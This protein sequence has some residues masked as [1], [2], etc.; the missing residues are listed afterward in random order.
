[1]M[2]RKRP[3]ECLRVMKQQQNSSTFILVVV[4]VYAKFILVF[5]ESLED[6]RKRFR[7]FYF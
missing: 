3:N 4:V 6:E 1:M 7:L 2:V 5:E